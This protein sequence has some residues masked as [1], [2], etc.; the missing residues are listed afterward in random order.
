MT[1]TKRLDPQVVTFGCRMNTYESEVMR[2]HARAAGLGD[3]I[4]VNTC[5]VTKEAERQA[6]QAVR[7]LRRDN[8]G[9]RIIVTGCAVQVNADLW[10]GMPEVDRVLGNAEKL[11]AEF[12]APGL[13]QQILVD[14]IMTVRETAEHLLAGFE[15]HTR[16]FVQV[17]QGCDHRCT[18]C[19][20][21]YARGPNRSVAMGRITEQ[22]RALVDNGYREVVLT[23]VDITAYG[24]DLPGTPPLGQMVRRLLANVPDLPRLRLTSLDPV[25]VDDDLLDLIGR[26]P[27]L[28]PHFHLSAQAGDDLILKRMKRRHLRHHVIELADRIR[29]LRPDAVL[30]ADII[31]GFPTETDEHFENSLRLVDEAGLTHLHV[32]PYSS[33]PGTPAARM[34]ALPGDVVKERAARLRAKGKAVMDAYLASRVGSEARVLVED[35]GRGH[36]EHYVPVQ[37]PATAPVGEIVTVRLAAV[38]GDTLIGEVPA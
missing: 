16:A 1:M 24:Q 9:A 25:E 7:K 36:C 20:I 14:D 30:G 29:S 22:V 34:P 10:A 32:F 26:E 11:K 18:F 13:N 19:I 31:A 21:P 33:R 27:R 8:P 17:Q 3:A 15:G 6:R 4:I 28:M 23:G 2:D 35:P 5:A 37:V 38:D 12:Y